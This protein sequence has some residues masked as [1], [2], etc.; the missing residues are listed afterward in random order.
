MLS[1]RTFLAAVTAPL[2]L[3]LVAC[4]GGSDKTTKAASGNGAAATATSP[5]GGGGGSVSNNDIAE[6][7]QNFAKAKSWKAE[8][9]GS[10]TFEYVAP[11]KYHFT[12][13]GTGEFI[14]IGAD[15][16][17]KV[18]PTWTKLPSSSSPGQ[19]F[20]PNDLND[21]IKA[22]QA[23]GVTKGGKDSVNG[24]SCEI[25]TYKDSA[26]A[27]EELCVADKLPIRVVSGTGSDKTTITFT[28]FNGNFDIKAP[29]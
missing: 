28:E 14:T 18:G 15:T 27:P 7:I 26:G 19:L 13:P 8:I 22:A 25:W 10:G 6:V 9:T 16:Y 12:I 29:I 2:L 23:S 4:G 5:S 24:K 11:D 21:E 3:A 20:N 17:V 1:K